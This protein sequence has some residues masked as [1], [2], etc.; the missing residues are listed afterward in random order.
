MK[1]LSSMNRP[2]RFPSLDGWRAV[3]IA[4]V[5]GY[6]CEFAVGFPQRLNPVMNWLFDGNL[7]VR[8]FFVIS[9]FLITHLLLQE[10]DQTGSVSLRN[11]YVRRGLR[12]LPVYFAYLLAIFVLQFV[13]SWY[14]APITWLGNLTFTTN[15]FPASGQTTHLW[16]LAVEEQFYLL[17]PLLLV[18]IGL[19]GNSRAIYWI[20]G[21]PLIVAPICRL[22]SCLKDLPA[23]FLPFLQEFSFFYNFDSLAI[24]CIAAV[25]LTRHGRVLTED[26][27]RFKWA[28]ICAGIAL[29]LVPYILSR[30][31]PGEIFIVAFGDSLQGLGF[32]VLLWQSILSP[33]LFMPLQWPAMKTL[34]ILSYSIYI[35]Q[36]T[37]LCNPQNFG[38]SRFWFM[39]FPG[40]LLTVFFVAALSY[41]GFE[42]PLLGLRARFRKP[43]AVPPAVLKHLQKPGR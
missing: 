35:W 23:I 39:R 3:S 32:A 14:Q 24:G 8:F 13:T 10:F 41:Y 29:I 25:L 6:H 38:F 28:S 20:L 15:F 22:L 5:L 33:R 17:W 19:R 7:G 36:Q 21:I 2:P 37:F 34:G 16:S 30:S 43:Q 42:R 18:L 9:G 26:L 4:L 1:E 11:F 40:A 12:I 31:F 27:N